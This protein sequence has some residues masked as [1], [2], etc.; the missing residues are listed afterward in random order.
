MH[1]DEN[2]KISFGDG[3]LW[4]DCPLSQEIVPKQNNIHH[5]RGIVLTISGQIID[6]IMRYRDTWVLGY[7]S[8]CQASSLIKV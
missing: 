6:D 5:E 3:T 1:S 8:I 2:G 7:F 4:T